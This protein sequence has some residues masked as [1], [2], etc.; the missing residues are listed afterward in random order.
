MT[1]I[2]PVFAASVVGAGVAGVVE[3]PRSC[4]WGAA[5]LVL[6]TVA[7]GIP[8]TM[9]VAVA[10]DLLARPGSLAVG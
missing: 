7:I 9:A 1:G 6:H 10:L 5:S 2:E 3:L 4:D 8:A